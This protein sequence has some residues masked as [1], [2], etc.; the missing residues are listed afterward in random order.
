MLGKLSNDDDE[1]G[2]LNV[3]QNSRCFKI[4]R[5]YSMAFNL[6]VLANFSGVE[7]YRTVSNLKEKIVVLCSRTPEN[8]K[9]G[10]F[11]SWPCNNGK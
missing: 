9:L 8:V 7:F 6:S 11:T 1:D 10:S 4:H 5:S 2:E 3:S